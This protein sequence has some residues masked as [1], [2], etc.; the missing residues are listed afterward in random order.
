MVIIDASSSAL[1]SPSVMRRIVVGY[2]YIIVKAASLSTH[3]VRRDGGMCIVVAASQRSE[4]AGALKQL[5]YNIVTVHCAV[6]RRQ[7]SAK[8]PTALCHRDV[9]RV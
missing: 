9:A 4:T 1:D 2:M 7:G 3:V 5:P 8:A 6:D